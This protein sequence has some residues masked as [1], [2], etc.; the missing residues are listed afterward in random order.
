MALDFETTD[1]DEM[2]AV[3]VGFSFSFQ[4]RI[5]YYVPLVASQGVVM[6]TRDALGLLSTL[7]S[8]KKIRLVGQNIKYDYKV[9]V[10]N[11]IEEVDLYFDTM[12]AAWVLDSSANVYNMDFLAHTYLDGLYDDTLRRGGPQ[13]ESVQ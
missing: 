13:G 2:K 1:I 6:D 10:R 3:P 5:A 7:L 4:D 11:G 9:M 12:V 8:E